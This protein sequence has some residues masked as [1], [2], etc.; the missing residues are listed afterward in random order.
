MVDC[1]AY[2]TLFSSQN[3]AEIIKPYPL[4]KIDETSLN[5]VLIPV[6]RP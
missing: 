2:N 6:F 3:A 1:V 4:N 5:V